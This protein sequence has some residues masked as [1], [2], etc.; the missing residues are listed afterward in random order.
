[1][2]YEAY[3]NGIGYNTGLIKITGDDANYR[4]TWGDG[5]QDVVQKDRDDDGDGIYD[6][7]NPVHSYTQDGQYDIAVFQ[8]Q[9]G[10]PPVRMRAFMYSSATNDITVGGTYLSDII[11]AGSGNDTLS[12]GGGRD[13]I[14]GADGNDR[15]N[16][17]TG[18]DFLLG[19]AGDDTLLGAAGTDL[20]GGD[21][22]ADV[23]RGGAD[24]DYLYGDAG[25]DRL[26]GDEGDDF[27]QGDA[28]VDRL[29][30]GAGSDTFGFAPVRD[31][32]G[33]PLPTD[34]DRDTIVDFQQGIDR[35]DLYSWS[36]DPFTLI[37]SGRFTGAGNELRV[38]TINGGTVVF[39]DVDGDRVADFSLRIEGIVN[40]TGSDFGY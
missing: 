34:P 21:T 39:A 19:G 11:T 10:L 38:S 3:W 23:L 9:S 7:A 1:M 32:E 18:D 24:R 20:L 40:L 31:G 35:I 4:V 26:F 29:T 17:Q 2:A 12:G 6:S 25:D 13:T 15:L 22:G 28:G 16:G 14:Q 27:L 8:A 36:N 5:T 30:G 37:G 33:N